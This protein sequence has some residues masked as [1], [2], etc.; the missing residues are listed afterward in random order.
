MAGE[1]IVIWRA[2]DVVNGGLLATATGANRV[3]LNPATLESSNG[4]IFKSEIDYRNAVPEVPKVAG[5]VNEVQDMGL[6]GLDV[7]LVGLFDKASTNADISNL[8]T[9]M[10]EDKKIHAGSNFS[11]PKGRFGLL[12]NDLP[13]F[14]VTPTDD[15]SARGYVLASVR[16]MREGEYKSKVGV[17]IILRFSG[18]IVGGLGT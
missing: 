16:F 7:Q 11:A 14:D 12:M 6:D 10:Q 17:V 5:Q 9:W 18:D 2:T 1:D 15:P 4:W 3:N 8:V 13:Q